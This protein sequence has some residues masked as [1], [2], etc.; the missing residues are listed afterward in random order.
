MRYELIIY[1]QYTISLVLIPAPLFQA[2]T[3]TIRN[4]SST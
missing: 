2:P 4:V 3:V 1:T